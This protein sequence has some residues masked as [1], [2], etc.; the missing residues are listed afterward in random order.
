MNSRKLY[1]TEADKTR[2]D[3]MI[4]TA[5]EL[6]GQKKKDVELL[7]KEL[8]RAKIVLS[9]DIPSNVVTMNSKVALRDLD[10]SERMEYMLVY[11]NDANVGNGAISVLAPI[12]TAMLGFAKGD[13]I[14][15]PV[16]SGTRR[17]RI[18]SILYQPEAAGDLSR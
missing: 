3:E 10:S 14:E 1:I 15:W 12:G 13:V 11:P 9:K 2:L 6:G 17:I 5:K 18:E 4:T 16:P 7:V 8:A